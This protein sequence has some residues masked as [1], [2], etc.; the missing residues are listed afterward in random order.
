MDGFYPYHEMDAYLGVV[1]LF[2]AALGAKA[3]RDRWVGSWIVIGV[4]GAILMLGR[5]TFVMDYLHRVPILG[6]SRIP[7]R[8]H[9]WVTL[10]VSTLAAVGVDRLARPGAVRLRPGVLVLAGL[11]VASLLILYATYRPAVADSWRW[12]QKEHAQKFGW[13]TREIGF[14]GARNLALFFA[15]LF[16]ASRSVRS[17]N[18]RSRAWWVAALPIFSI[19]DM[20]RAHSNDVPTVDPS[21]WTKAPA[22]VDAL[23]RDPSLIRMYGEGTYSS[24]EPGHASRPIDFMVVR[25]TIAWSL[26]AAWNLPSTGGETPILSRRRFRF[27]EWQTPTR[28]ALEGLSHAISATPSVERLGAAEKVGPQPT[29]TATPKPC[30]EPASVGRPVYAKD[31]AGGRQGAEENGRGR[32][33]EGRRRGSGAHGRG[34]GRGC[35]DRA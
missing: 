30:P 11:L 8:F 17:P 23:R 5:F 18:P 27:G 3:W 9:L 29:S 21:Y 19:V 4:I 6:S 16:V 13:I 2:L 32:R 25:E 1:G 12:T 31:E 20:A 34:R 33:D 24:G 15:T 10:A 7:V 14:A 35:P 28:Y 26:P 22:S